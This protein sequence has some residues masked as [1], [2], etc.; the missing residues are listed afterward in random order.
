MGDHSIASKII[1]PG[2]T[3][4]VEARRALYCFVLGIVVGAQCKDIGVHM[5]GI[6][7]EVEGLGIGSLN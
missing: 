2:N 6:V 7:G 4:L 5:H 1:Y 3:L